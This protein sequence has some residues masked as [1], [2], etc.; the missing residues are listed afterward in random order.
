[1]ACVGGAVGVIA[2]FLVAG[3]GQS[4]EST[5]ERST[6]GVGVENQKVPRRQESPLPPEPPDPD[7]SLAACQ[8]EARLLRGQLRFY[9]GI[10]REWPEEVPEIFDREPL[11]E[12]L[13]VA[14]DELAVIDGL[15][16]SEYPCLVTV[17]LPDWQHE[18]C[19]HLM[20]ALPDELTQKGA[21]N[22]R[23]Y[24]LTIED[25]PMRAIIT[26]ASEQHWS[27]DLSRRTKWRSEVASELL[28]DEPAE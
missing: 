23:T 14:W 1:M 4:P 10:W 15:D 21:H 6:Q 18:C 20:E 3:H 2:G 26:L 28:Q 12:A 16:C 25:G 5:E 11:E 17:T 24:A 22:Y 8:F 27:E 13:S 19:T 9:E 7:P